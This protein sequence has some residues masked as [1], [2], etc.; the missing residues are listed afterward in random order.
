MTVCGE[1]ICVIVGEVSETNLFGWELLISMGDGKNSKE[2]AEKGKVILCYGKR[3]YVV[4]EERKEGSPDDN[5]ERRQKNAVKKPR[6][7]DLATM[8]EETHRVAAE[9]NAERGLRSSFQDSLISPHEKE[10]STEISEV[11][12]PADPLP[13]WLIKVLTEQKKKSEDDT[14]EE[15]DADVFTVPLPK[16]FVSAPSSSEQPD[17]SAVLD[18][19]D[20][21][22]AEKE[23][24]DDFE[25]FGEVPVMQLIPTECEVVV[26]NG[27][28]P[29][30][31]LAFDHQ[32]TRF[33]C[34]GWDY[35]V[36]LYEFQKMDY[37]FRPSRELAPCESHV[38]NDLA[39]S[40]NGEQL[41]VASGHAQIRILDRQG[42]Q[43]AETVRGDQYLVDLSNTSGHTSAV[44]CC[45]WHPLI[46]TEFLSCGDDGTLR[47]W[48]LDDYKELRHCITKQ[49]KVIKTKTG[50]GRRAIA[51]CCAYSRDGK[52]I[53]AGCS[54]GSIQIWKNGNLFVNTTYLNRTAHSKPV[55]SIQFSANG[56]QILSRS[57]DGTLKLFDLKSF[58]EPVLMKNDLF[59]DF[60]GTD[61]GFSPRGELVFTGTS[62]SD[63]GGIDG[64]LLFFDS[65][66]FELV[67]QIKYPKLSCMRIKWHEKI[68]QI[69]VALSD[70]SLRLYYDPVSSAR[71][72]LLCVSR[73]L[74]RARQQEVVREEMIL[75]PLTLE[76]F[77][78]RGE[79]G[80]EKEVTTWR[81]RK[82]LRMQDNKLRPD[83]RK[84]ADMPMSGPSSG[85]R[86]MGTKRNRDFLADTD[87]RASI[88]RH[89]EEAEKNPYYVAKAYL[90]NQPVTIF[91]EKTTAPEEEE[92]DAELQPLY[93]QPMIDYHF[94][95]ELEKS[96][97]K[98]EDL[99]NFE[100]FKIGRGTYGHVYKAHPRRPDI[101]GED[102]KKEYALKLIEGQGFSMS[103]CREIALLRELKHPN[104][105]RLRRV[106]LTLERKVWFCMDFAEHDLWHIIKFHRAAKQK[107][108]PVLVPKGMVKS[109]LYQILD[110]IHYLHTNWILHRDLKPANILV[111]GEG[112]GVE[113][114]RVKIGDMG[115][116]RV[117]YNPLRPL[118]E[119]DPVV[120]T[121]WYR[122]PE[123]LLGAKHYTKA[124]DIW[125]IGCIFAELL[126]S[127]P[128]FFCRE[129]DIKASS[130][131]HQDQ[132]NRIF[133][134][135]GFPS[136]K[137]WEDLKKM[138]EYQKLIQDF[139][140]TS[141]ANCTLQRYME[142]HKIRAETPAFSLLQRLLTMDPIKRITAQ[143][144]LDD[145]YF[146]EDP[147]PTAD[148]FNGCA[149]PYP[150][151]EYLS[152]ENEVKSGSGSKTQQAP[153]PQQ[154]QQQ[155]ITMHQQQPIIE[156]AAK[157]MR[158]QSTQQMPPTQPQMEPPL[159]NPSVSGIFASNV[160]NQDY[161]PVGSG[162][163]AMQFE[164]QHQPPV[165][166]S[167][168]INNSNMQQLPYPQ[169]QQHQIIS[170]GPNMYQQQPQI[171]MNQPM[172]P[173]SQPHISARPMQMPAQTNIMQS[174]YQQPIM[175]PSGMIV[176]QPAPEMMPQQGQYMMP[177]QQQW[178]PMQQRYQ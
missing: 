157:K 72:A 51:T 18:Q 130:P 152:D 126:T 46:K 106:F 178:P 27:K 167:Q 117:F 153:P 2:E 177:Q 10:E 85:G 3:E 84:P 8:F 133:T 128:V 100:G 24:D 66:N 148:V 147:K 68:N 139:K 75:S 19:G 23:D 164:Q 122:A 82:F 63:D 55:T 132:L 107:K 108:T 123:L 20:T 96:R 69:L 49:R 25:D 115:F 91:Q 37:T 35:A 140:R 53:G 54:D 74:R 15:D 154:S 45:C 120:V 59:T 64:A 61:C 5:G 16:N 159:I 169:H 156:P 131:Y 166:Q 26:L 124:I 172:V 78:P 110:G 136:E 168:Q 97:E 170:Q 134:V 65:S 29:V 86:Q 7:F 14:K 114:G 149:I 30:S 12:D 73:P 105:I 11:S 141:Y 121:F 4:S 98:V 42:K 70:G 58:K 44:N 1:E 32:G 161:P 175:Q 33:A 125:A 111:T 67:Y 174:S 88:L 151:R 76:M 116:A 92:G 103:A 150:K 129:E 118:A 34:G 90:K 87:V 160:S 165:I 135:M 71:G 138:P 83:F 95:E 93:K 6:Q 155:P 31:A 99:F 143:E 94:K 101:F 127:E 62:T 77:Q 109:L 36:N 28:K 112:P 145:D 52:L 158:L 81:L 102:T 79:E 17:P 142:K 60:E 176:P 113:R 89:A 47:I 21:M 146:K 104:L 80:E 22:S 119:L 57:L 43:W 38:I 171:S 163:K 41:L 137:E 13:L 9:R 56:Q 40:T 50:G 39:F 48:S 173:T 144:A 162:S